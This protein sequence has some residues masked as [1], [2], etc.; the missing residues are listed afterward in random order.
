MGCQRQHQ[1][2]RRSIFTAPFC[3]WASMPSS[4]NVLSGW[5]SVVPCSVTCSC[6]RLSVPTFVRL[7]QPRW[8]VRRCI[9]LPFVPT[10]A[11]VIV[12]LFRYRLV[13]SIG[14]NERCP[15]LKYSL[16]PWR[17][18]FAQRR[19]IS[20][21]I[22][23]EAVDGLFL[24]RCRCLAPGL[25]AST[26]RSMNVGNQLRAHLILFIPYRLLYS[27]RFSMPPFVLTSMHRLHLASEATMSPALVKIHYWALSERNDM[28]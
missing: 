10:L 19:A 7:R 16:L 8:F 6:I 5:H 23:T 27:L 14:H 20:N 15:P 17:G 9:S 11:V 13:T 28:E 2:L 25:S 26:P 1:G 24:Q 12:L 18:T 22:S 21:P 3:V 4:R